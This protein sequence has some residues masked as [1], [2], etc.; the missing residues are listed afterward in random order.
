MILALI[1]VT[2]GCVEQGDLSLNYH[3]AL[4]VCFVVHPD[5]KPISAFG[6]HALDDEIAAVVAARSTQRSA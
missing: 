4:C 1:V 3:P 6:G 5:A 2:C